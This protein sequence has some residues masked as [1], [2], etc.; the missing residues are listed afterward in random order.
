MKPVDVEDA[1]MFPVAAG[2]LRR[3]LKS[4]RTR[5]GIFRRRLSPPLEMSV[6]TNLASESAAIEIGVPVEPPRNSLEKASE[7][8][9]A[10][11]RSLDRANIK[12]AAQ[13]AAIEKLRSRSTSYRA[14]Y[15][16]AR[17]YT[18]LYQQGILFDE[19]TRSQIDFSAEC[20]LG[21]LPSSIP[22]ILGLKRTFGG[23]T[24]CDCVE[25]VDIDKHSVVPNVH[26][27]AIDM[28]NLTAYGGLL[29]VD[30]LMTTGD[31]VGQTLA[32]FDRPTLVV[33][34]YRRFEVPQPSDE[35]RKSCGVSASDLLLF[36]SGN[37]VVGFEPVLEALAGL[38]DNV[39]LAALVRLK[40]EAYDAA[41]KAKALELG[42]AHRV[43]F[44][45]FVPYEALTSI[46]AGADIGLITSDTANPNAAV[47]LPN[48][49]F[50]YLTSGLPVVA[51]P[52]PDVVKILEAHQ[53]GV[54]LPE[55]TAS[56]W[57]EAISHVMN[58]LPQYRAAVA[59]ARAALTWE[60]L[61]DPLFEY[62]GRPKTITMVGFRDFSRY[63]RFRR[64]AR[65]LSERGARVKA[66]FNSIDPLPIKIPNCDFYYFDNRHGVGPGL[67]MAPLDEALE[68]SADV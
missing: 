5:L 52:M 41:V 36:A 1:A 45:P 54:W 39:H 47:A 51:P 42:I 50:D 62:L 10:Y 7:K 29:T 49:F 44:L 3:K 30:K 40:P 61:E 25:N 68:A 57:R 24:V 23:M 20:Y 9:E 28:V 8:I 38:P 27:P 67:R 33:P 11:R 12:I 55:V 2:E 65:T 18:A 6:R 43:H 21:L 48:R 17:N 22:A 35:L 15:V 60:R 46:A 19:I 32:R 59:L 16:I 66:V 4:W 56:A 53:C 34:N 14:H 13:S 58:N 37:V 64:I 26:R 31:A 63:Q